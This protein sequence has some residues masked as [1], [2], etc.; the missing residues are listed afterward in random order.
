MAIRT[1]MTQLGAGLLGQLLAADTGHRGQRID[2]G[3]HH[4]EFVGY[5]DKNFDTVLGPIVVRR[6]YYHCTVCQRGIVPRD[7]EL[8]VT[9]ASLSPG[10]RRMVARAAAAEPFATAADLL[11]ELAGIRLSDKRIERS[12]ETDGAAAAQRIAA[13]APAIACGKVA[14]L[15]APA[16]RGETP[17][18]LYIAIDGTGVP[19]VPAA[20]TGRAGKSGDGRAHTREVKL[21]CLFTQTRVDDDGRPVRDP[22][23][24]SYLATFAPADQFATLVHAEARR[25]GADHIRQL[26]V[27]GDGAPWIWKLATQV[28]PEATPIVDIYHARE[29]LHDL[30][31]ALTGVLD[32]QYPDWLTARLADLDAGDIETLVA[33]TTRLAL[34]G[35]L[36]RDTEKALAYFKTNAHRMRY[37]YFR[38]HGMFVGSGT[39]EA[40]CKAVVGQRLKLSGMRW[41]I[42][43]A[44]GILTLRCQHASGR[45][46]QIWTQPHNQTATA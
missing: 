6:A 26:V 9:G 12:A 19:M 8:G 37:A 10:L 18:K 28:A 39:V 20:T 31:A 29:H 44:T 17:D 2:C 42:P 7:D 36:A 24:T 15:P 4:A 41:N 34:T 35:D 5:R 3:G 33:Q 23:S 13:E 11:A 30:A 21:A 45:W 14:V 25:R 32:D 43:G 22:D 1:A 27:L 38:D 16:D 40:G 46:E